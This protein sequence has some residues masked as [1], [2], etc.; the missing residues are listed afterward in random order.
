[1]GPETQT[2]VEVVTK[3]RKAAF[4]WHSLRHRWA[5]ICVDIKKMKEGALMAIGG[6]EN[7]GTVQTR[8]YRSG[9]DNMVE[10]LAYTGRRSWSSSSRTWTRSGGGSRTP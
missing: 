8:Y 5:R 2:Y 1:M 9:H 6:W 3:R 10:G 4:P 7:I